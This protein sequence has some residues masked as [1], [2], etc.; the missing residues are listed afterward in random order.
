V[1]TERIYVEEGAADRFENLL[2]ERV[3]ALRQRAPDDRSTEAHD[4][5]AVTFAGQLGVV[6]RQ[7]ADATSKGARVA[8]GG[9]RRRDLPGQFFP[10]TVLFSATHDM[11]VMKEETFGPLVP[12]MRVKDAEEALRLSNDTHLGLNATVFG[13]RKKAVAFARRL[14]SGQV[15]VNDVLVN[16]FVVESPL[17]GWKASGLGIRHGIESLRQWTR[18]EAIT[19]GRPMLAPL[20]R[21]VARK[22]AFPYD[23][24]FLGLIRRASRLLYRRGIREKLR[25]P[26]KFTAS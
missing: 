20:E 6:E 26:R 4:L 1:R 23:A 16:Y 8:V 9:A 24:R 19:E 10:P 13:P 15:M 7:I 11:E 21:L 12:V 25:R 14:Q 17:G 3:R 5:G 2:V 22:L 18:T